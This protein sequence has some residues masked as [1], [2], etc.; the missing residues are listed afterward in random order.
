[1]AK[2]LDLIA[3]CRLDLDGLRAQLERYRRLG[4]DA[5]E[6]A[7]S[8]GSLTISFGAGVD[9]ALLEETIAVETGCC[10]FFSFDYSAPDRLLRIG[11]ERAEQDAALDALAFALGQ[12]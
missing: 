10:T 1:M 6:V 7:R 2:D 5:A 3:E 9:R 4:V 8:P 11:V 12:E